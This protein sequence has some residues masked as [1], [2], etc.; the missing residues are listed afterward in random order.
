[1]SD[2]RETSAGD[3]YLLGK[4][5]IPSQKPQPRVESVSLFGA[6]ARGYGD[7]LECRLNYKPLGFK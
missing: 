4:Y 3:Y 5:T 7:V 2:K 6:M 1:M